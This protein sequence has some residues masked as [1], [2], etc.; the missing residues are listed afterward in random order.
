[1]DEY[2]DDNPEALQDT[3][4]IK[5]LKSAF[6]NLKEFADVML[7]FIERNKGKDITDIDKSEFDILASWQEKDKYYDTA[8]V[9]VIRNL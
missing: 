3:E 4:N 2:L 5:Q 6:S 7:G 8:V 1:M 9:N